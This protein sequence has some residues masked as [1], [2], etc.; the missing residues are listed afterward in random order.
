MRLPVYDD[1][2]RVFDICVKRPKQQER[3]RNLDVPAL[4]VPSF[5]IC[6]KKPRQQER[7][8]SGYRRYRRPGVRRASFTS[9]P[10]AGSVGKWNYRHLRSPKM[11][12]RGNEARNNVPARVAAHCRVL[13]HLEHTRLE[14]D[15]PRTGLCNYRAL[16][17]SYERRAPDKGNAEEISLR[18]RRAPRKL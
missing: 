6:V 3:P 17:R 9:P 18:A 16:C 4:R 15:R 5:D 8:E 2:T 1:R 12:G 14:N 11:S 10:L 7:P 13:A